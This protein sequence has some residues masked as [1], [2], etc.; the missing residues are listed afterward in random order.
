MS[1]SLRGDLFDDLQKWTKKAD[2]CMALGTSLCGMNADQLVTKTAHRAMSA[3]DKRIKKSAQKSLGSVIVSLQQT[4]YDN[5]C[6]LRI[7]A[8]LDVVMA[9]LAKEMGLTIDTHMYEPNVPKELI[10][11]PDVFI[12][13]YDENGNLS[14][15]TKTHWNLMKG[16]KIK[17][18]DGPGTGYEGIVS[19][20]NEDGHYICTLP[21]QREG[22]ISQG[23]VLS[24]YMLGSWW[25]ESAI[26]GN[27]PK[28]PDILQGPHSVY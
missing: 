6:T 18:T 26:N 14:K 1:G 22:S 11:R 8:K 27:A 3:W 13:P 5:I 15:N 19:G 10:V 2:L 23:K 9:L 28:L 20:K 12:V 24:K 7:Y 25:V 17:V 21:N 4:Q 16:A